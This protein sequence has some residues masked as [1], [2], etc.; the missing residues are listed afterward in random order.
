MRVVWRILA[1][2]FAV[3]AK[4]ARWQALVWSERGTARAAR[5]E[6]FFRKSRGQE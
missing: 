1:R 3:R 2:W 6:K 5:S 4:S